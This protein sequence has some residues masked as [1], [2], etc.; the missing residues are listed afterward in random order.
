MFFLHLQLLICS[1]LATDAFYFCKL[2]KIKAVSREA[3]EKLQYL[4]FAQELMK[5]SSFS[6][7]F[8]PLVD[9]V[10]NLIHFLEKSKILFKR[11][12][13]DLLKMGEK[14]SEKKD[15]DPKTQWNEL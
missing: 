4:Q 7:H 3:D 12:E 2:Q 5:T 1:S 13:D 10:N 14:E 6:E 9:L 15:G 8:P 11:K